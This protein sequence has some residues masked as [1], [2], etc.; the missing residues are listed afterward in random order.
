MVTL[1][2]RMKTIADMV[3]E[4]LSVA[5]IGC[6]HGFVSIYLVNERKAPYALAMDVNEGPLL[7]AKEH[8]AQYG[9]QDRISTR[10]SDG[11]VGLSKGEV[12]AAV[13]AG[14]GGRL[15]MRI[16][17]DSADKFKQMKSLVLSPHSDIPLVRGFLVDNGFEIQDEEM[18]FDEG[19]YYSIIRCAWVGAETQL[20]D[21]QKEYGP[22]LLEKKHPVLKE[23]LTHEA[24]KMR[25][26]RER[27]AAG[28]NHSTRVAEIDRIL[29]QI[30]EVIR[31]M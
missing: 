23:Y 3:P 25:E 14:M 17:V 11:A 19:K 7:R 21:I 20:S 24:V 26:I 16:I 28:E 5:D 4:G 6:D 22:K 1:S 31:D 27:L 18:V 13:I 30:T 2:T 12:E 10:L 9:L 8:I 29:D 15:T